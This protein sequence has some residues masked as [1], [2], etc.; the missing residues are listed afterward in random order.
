[1]NIFHANG[2]WNVNNNGL[3]RGDG[4]ICRNGDNQAANYVRL[5]TILD[6]TSNTLAIGEAIP[7]WCTHTWWWWFNGSTATCGVPLNYRINQGAP[8]LTSQAGDWGR[9]YSFFSTHPGGAQFEL[10]DASTRFIADT[11]DLTLYRQLATISGG[12]AAQIP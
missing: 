6:G 4:L 12:E 10:A 11:I 3:D 7:A 5:A 9:N 1:L 8:Y 2:K